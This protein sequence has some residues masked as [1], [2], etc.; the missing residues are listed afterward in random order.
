MGLIGDNCG[1]CQAAASAPNDGGIA[2]AWWR[3]W[4]QVS[5]TRPNLILKV[6]VAQANKNTG[7]IGAGIVGIFI[8]VIVGWY[9]MKRLI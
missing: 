3:G 1:R 2:G 5:R 9:M 4:A 6:M 8:M 7:Y